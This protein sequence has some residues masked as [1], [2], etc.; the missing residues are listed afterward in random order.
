MEQSVDVV[1]VGAGV[2]G[3]VAAREL[4][5]AG[6]DVLVLEARDRVGGR[7]LNAPL[8]DGS[9]IDVGGQWVGPTQHKVLALL[10]NLGLSTF[11]TLMAG[12]HIA[13]LGG[14]RSDYTGRIPRL[15][16]VTLADIGQT[17]WRL[18]RM[19]SAVPTAEPWRAANANRLDAQTFDSWLRQTARTRRGRS[20]FRLVTEAV[21]SSGP[22]DMSALWAG[23]Y[24]G[25]AGG[26]DALID[27]AGGAQQDRIV[28]GAQSIALTIA[29]ELGDRVVLNSPVTEIDWSEA[30]AT[31]RAPCRRVRARHVVV[32]LPPPLASRIRYSPGLPSDRDQLVQRMPM[33]RVIK[34]NVVYDEPFWRADGWSGQANSDTRPLGTVFDNTPYSGGPGILVGFLEGRHADAASRLHPADRRAHIVDDLA[35]YFGPQARSPVNVVELDWAAEEFSRGCYGAFATPGTLT[36]FGPHLRRPI[37][38]LRWAGTETATRW[39]GYMDGAVESGQRAAQ[40]IAAP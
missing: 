4:V 39:A 9:P 13:E 40:E 21:F 23:F 10:N 31:V 25:A 26:L 6:H 2:A 38:P 24:I 27:T 14:C 7:L 15:D 1:V 11:P 17:Q 8:P 32:A 36:R 35:G 28:G 37:G 5:A 33:G 12:R 29:G 3:L 22:E 30:Q 18:D 19:A 20:F 16:P 34:V